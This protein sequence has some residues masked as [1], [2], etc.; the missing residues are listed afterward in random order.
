[1][2]PTIH[3]RRA[4]A[5]RRVSAKGAL[6][7]PRGGAGPLDPAT[8]A[9]GSAISMLVLHGLS[10]IGA[11]KGLKLYGIRNPSP[12]TIFNFQR[13]F[14][15]FFSASLTFYLGIVQGKSVNTA[16][17]YGSF[18]I[19]VDALRSILNEDHKKVGISDESQLV[20][21]VLP[22]L[23]LAY[24][25]LT[26]DKNADM[27]TTL[28][29]AYNIVRGVLYF[30]AAEESGK[31]MGVKYAA[32]RA[33]TLAI[34]KWVGLALVCY[35][36]TLVGMA[37]GVDL[38]KLSAYVYIPVILGLVRELVLAHLGKGGGFNTALPS[39]WL[40]WGVA[41]VGTLAF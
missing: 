17:G 35:G 33:T 27:V 28:T 13:E 36:M 32:D 2:P 25:C 8:V 10:T 30:A 3:Q 19:I 38:Y 20:L 7:I 41:V 31:A 6:D 29:G 12:S 14:S 5:P 4:F 1:M 9:K 23:L 26:N 11:V 22:G 18:P 24:A 34:A 15:V 37:K 21:V 40:V 16:V 39:A